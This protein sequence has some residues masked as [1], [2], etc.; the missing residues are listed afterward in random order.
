MRTPEQVRR[1][2]LAVRLHEM[3]GAAQPDQQDAIE[4]EY[5]AAKAALLRWINSLKA[6]SSY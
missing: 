2:E 5:E 4:Y 6:A 3:K 1:F